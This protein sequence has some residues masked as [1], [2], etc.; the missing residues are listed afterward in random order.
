MRDEPTAGISVHHLP[1]HDALVLL[2]TDSERGLSSAEADRRLARH[3]PNIMPRAERRGWPVRVAAQLHNPL[4][5]V[6]L[7]AAAVTY[8]IG[9]AVNTVVILGVVFANTVVGFVQE[10]RAE[11]A[12]DALAQMITVTARVVRDG[13]E[14]NVSSRELVPGDVV[15]VKAGDK[16]AADL[17]LMSVGGLQVDESALTGESVPVVKEQVV[18]APETVLADR[19]N[20]AFSGTLVTAGRGRGVV[21]ATGEE[22]ELG[23]MHRLLAE[24]SELQT[25]L[26]RRLTRFARI[27]TVV[28]VALA[29]VT[30]V[31]GLARGESVSDMLVAAVALAVGAIPEALPAAVSVSLAIGVSRM[32]RRRAIVRRLPAA[33]TL[34]S[35]TVICTDKTGTLT[36]N[37]MT[38]QTILAGGEL[39]EVSGGGYSPQGALTRAGRPVS[40]AGLP[41]LRE[42]LRAGLLCG[43][44]DVRVSERVWEPVG[45]PMEAALAVAAR[46][47]GLE[48]TAELRRSPRI[49][50]LPFDSGRRYM[51]TVHR[52][53]DGDVALYIKGAV[54]QVLAMC[55]RSLAADGRVAV[56]SRRLVIEAAED[57]GRRG[58]RVLAFAAGRP[59]PGEAADLEP[60]GGLTFLGVQALMDPPR[61]EAAPAV[62]AC[63]RA[64]I[65][66]KM[67]TG[68]HPATAVAVAQ[69]VGLT[70]DGVPGVVSG[71]ELARC[72]E[73]RLQALVAGT[74]VFARVSG[75]QKLR[76]VRALQAGGEVVA[77]TGDGVNDAPALSQADIGVAM[78][79]GGTEVAREASD[80]VLADDNFATIEAAVEEGRHTFDNLKKFIA[81]TLPTNLAEGLLILVAIAVGAALPILP[82]QILWINMTT[83]VLLGLTLA[84][85]RVEPGIMD[86]AP[87]PPAQPL[88]TADIIRRILLV[89]VLLLAAA[90][91]L[92]EHE[93]GRG[94]TTAE[95]RTVAAN[96]FVFVE[97]AYLFNC[98]SL[99]GRAAE[100][101]FFSNRWL[102]GGVTLTGVLQ[103]LFTYWPPMNHLFGTAPVGAVSWLKVLGVSAAT[104][105]IVEAE[106]A[107]RRRGVRR[108]TPR[109]P[110]ARS[111][112][113]SG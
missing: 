84:F 90:F 11:T 48:R 23:Q 104:W 27:L 24:T 105:A 40:L 12:L 89:S 55:D 41:A 99:T 22:T 39:F 20:M 78:G 107:I 8:A 6:L 93:L 70:S 14:R 71:A 21:V 25:P 19:A 101:G 62:R 80:I 17:R 35:T 79:R 100:L 50:V 49:H 36:E 67:I 46:K 51:A 45:D 69:R 91:A 66:V 87:R 106:K 92:F 76:L 61:P 7:V 83:A 15:V 103:V 52:G 88:L 29:A 26:T 81:W 75:E 32:A 85:E 33:E 94:A 1:V 2:K 57:L 113:R 73:D 112:G 60:L 64:G 54:E 82:A 59:G 34:G 44:G 53:P 42:C 72:P 77:M 63:R 97:L 18:L 74:E 38:V 95:A 16:L 58:Q 43:D 108:T 30:F 56:L 10:S 28:I 31:I 13:R 65:A 3:G 4:V 110:A 68:D 37:A 98:R 5:Y 109:L 47:A 96:V 86:R 9:E 111:A 102:I